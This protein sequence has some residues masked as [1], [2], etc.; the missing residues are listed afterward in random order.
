VVICTYL[1]SCL[2]VLMLASTVLA[3]DELPKSR[4]EAVAMEAKDALPLTRFYDPPRPLP[5]AAPGTLPLIAWAHGTTG[6]MQKTTPEQLV[7]ARDRLTGK[8]WSG[9]CR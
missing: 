9:N 8:P 6:L 7:C 3:D 2:A 1:A 5:T 4:A